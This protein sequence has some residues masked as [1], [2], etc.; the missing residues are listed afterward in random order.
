[1]IYHASQKGHQEKKAASSDGNGLVPSKPCDC[2][3][4]S[5]APAGGMKVLTVIP[6]R[7]TQ[8]NDTK[9]KIFVGWPATM[10]QTVTSIHGWRQAQLWLARGSSAH[11]VWMA[12]S[13]S[14]K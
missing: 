6:D 9:I 3:K 8:M 10:V 13:I 1:M 11:I 4:H 2:P 5:N 14:M 12:K 7:V